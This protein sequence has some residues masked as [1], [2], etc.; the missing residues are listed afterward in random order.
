MSDFRQL[1]RKPTVLKMATGEGKS[2]S[3]H[4]FQIL[5]SLGRK[6]KQKKKPIPFSKLSL[7]V[8]R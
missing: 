5:C 3:Q 8:S 4:I 7:C 6:Q 2:L 1:K